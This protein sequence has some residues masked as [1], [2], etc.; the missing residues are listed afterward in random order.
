MFTFSPMQTAL[1]PNYVQPNSS[2]LQYPKK[3]SYAETD[4]KYFRFFVNFSLSLVFSG[5]FIP[6]IWA[7]RTA[8]MSTGSFSL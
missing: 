1:P 8:V 3:K 7:T 5:N 4:T 2:R 6:L